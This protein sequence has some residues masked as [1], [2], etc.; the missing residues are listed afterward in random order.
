MG[1]GDVPR[2][3]PDSQARPPD[4]GAEADRRQTR[5]TRRACV[6]VL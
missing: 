4:A 6:A 3:R 2:D 1:A 5:A